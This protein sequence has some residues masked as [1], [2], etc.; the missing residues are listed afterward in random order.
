M[1]TAIWFV[2]D[3]LFDLVSNGTTSLDELPLQ[4]QASFNVFPNPNEG[5]FHLDL[6]SDDEF[7]IIIYDRLGKKYMNSRDFIREYIRSP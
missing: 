7:G 6:G 4:K 1:D 3:F 5:S 2:R